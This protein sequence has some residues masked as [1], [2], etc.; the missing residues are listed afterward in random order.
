MHRPSCLLA[1]P[2]PLGPQWRCIIKPNNSIVYF[3]RPIGMSVNCSTPTLKDNWPYSF[4][5]K[6]FCTVSS[7]PS[8]GMLSSV[9]NVIYY[10]VECFIF[11]KCC[12]KPNPPHFRHRMLWYSTFENYFVNVFKSHSLE[13]FFKI[14]FCSTQ[15]E[16]KLISIWL[17][18]ESSIFLDI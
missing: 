16:F 18:L 14:S 15:S 6:E 12:L 7:C 17:I 1:T 4:F 3:V 13:S 10:E 11:D 5:S 8:S 9:S 2:R